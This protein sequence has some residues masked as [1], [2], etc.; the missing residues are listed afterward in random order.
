ML[1]KCKDFDIQIV[2]ASKIEFAE[3]LLIRY[4]SLNIIWNDTEYIIR[5]YIDSAC[6]IT[7]EQKIAGY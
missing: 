3:H 4:D 5:N 2:Y 7:N 6:V 1:G